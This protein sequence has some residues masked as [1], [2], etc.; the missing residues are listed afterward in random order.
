MKESLIPSIVLPSKVYILAGDEDRLE[1]FNLYFKNCV[2]GY[3]TEWYID[4]DCPYGRQY[5]GFWRLE[6]G[7]SL[8]G[9]PPTHQ[10]F[11][12]IIRIFDRDFSLLSERRIEVELV[13]R[14]VLDPCYLLCIGDSMTRAAVYVSQAQETLPGVVTLGTRT[15]DEGVVCSE[16]RGGWKVSDYLAPVCE[17]GASPF[18]FPIGDSD[19]V[20]QGHTSFWKN[21]AHTHTED[22]PYQGFQKLTRHWGS[23]EAAIRYDQEGFPMEKQEGDVVSQT[24]DGEEQLWVWRQE[25]E[26]WQLL[27]VTPQ[28][29]MRFDDYMK[30]FEFAF[31]RDGHVVAPHIVS[32]LFGANDFHKTNGI[33]DGLDTFVESVKTIIRSV[34]SYNPA[35]QVVLH[36]PIIGASQDAWGISQG[37]SGNSE[38]YNRN[39]QELGLAILDIWDNAEALRDGIWI[40]PTLIVLDPEFGFDTTEEPANCYSTKQVFRQNNW[41]HP[42]VAGYRQMGDAF[43]A[44]IQ[45]IRNRH[46]QGI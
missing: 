1:Q 14:T 15:Y 33:T 41:V 24:L 28:W 21:A 44:V 5:D 22:Y 7:G 32:L 43:A 12:L 3:T 38:R 18:V 20:Y 37:C 10:A 42:N 36:L 19:S 29:E 2:I 11:P 13:P 23:A 25:A 46:L 40:S 4:I 6:T 17:S 26:E 31:V 8:T 45:H 35:T 39:M 34:K 9:A 16:G 27:N 30:R